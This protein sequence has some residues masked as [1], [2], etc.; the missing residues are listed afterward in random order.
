MGMASCK[1]ARRRPRAPD[2]SP[3]ALVAVKGARRGWSVRRVES[4]ASVRAHRDVGELA[5]GAP[6]YYGTE[7]HIC[8]EARVMRLLTIGG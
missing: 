1:M 2:A 8:Q 4:G 7:F 6:E 3:P 5:D